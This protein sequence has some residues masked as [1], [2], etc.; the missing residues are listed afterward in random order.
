VNFHRRVHI[1]GSDIGTFQAGGRQDYV[2]TPVLAIYGGDFQLLGG[3]IVVLEAKV[4][5]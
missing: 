5:K 1:P 3:A 4:S 2:N